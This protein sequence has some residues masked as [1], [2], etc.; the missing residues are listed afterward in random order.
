VFV[1]IAGGLRI[2]DPAIELA[3]VCSLLSS[4]EDKALPSNVSMVGEVGLSGEIRAV[5]RIDQRIAEADKLGLDAIFIPKA[6]AKGLDKKNYKI[7]IRTA[8]KVEDIYRLLF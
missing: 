2:E 5:N 3:V 1:N 7:D 8:N 6:N 4:F